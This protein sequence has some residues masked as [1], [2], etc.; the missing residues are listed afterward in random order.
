MFRAGTDGSSDANQGTRARLTME[1][2]RHARD[3]RRVDTQRGLLWL[4]D[5]TRGASSPVLD[6]HTPMSKNPIRWHALAL[7]GSGF[8]ATATAGL[9]KRIIRTFRACGDSCVRSRAFRGDTLS[10]R[11]GT[12]NPSARESVLRIADVLP[13]AAGSESPWL[14]SM[15]DSKDVALLQVAGMRRPTQRPSRGLVHDER[16]KPGGA[17][18]AP[19]GPEPVVRS[20]VIDV[21]SL[22]VILALGAL[23]GLGV[24]GPVRA[25]LRPLVLHV[26]ARLGSCDELDFGR[27]RLESGAVGRYLVC[28]LRRRGNDHVVVPHLAAHRLFFVTALACGVAITFRVMRRRTD[29][30]LDFAEG[31]HVL[32]EIGAEGTREGALQQTPALA[33]PLVDD[34][35]PLPEEADVLPSPVAGVAG[36]MTSG[37]VNVNTASH[38]ELVTLPGIGKVIA[39]ETVDHRTANGPFTSVGQLAQVR[40]IGGAILDSIRELVNV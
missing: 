18:S 36:R 32:N 38:A 5:W 29:R 10:G 3:R 25:A 34:T 28:Y 27:P 23:V 11:R 39:T 19:V 22:A 4:D 20:E 35:L 26:R 30:T 6:L 14:P 15:G 1:G 8:D 24:E 31:A 7:A 33:D 9:A 37:P 12:T 2:L 13:W 17:M 16:P 21:A 40:G